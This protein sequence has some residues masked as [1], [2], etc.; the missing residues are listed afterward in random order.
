MK[1]NI[2]CLLLTLVAAGAHALPKQFTAEYTLSTMGLEIGDT[3]RTLRAEGDDRF[4]FE[5]LSVPKGIATWFIS[6]TLLERSVWQ[7]VN[8]GVQPQ[9]YLYRRSGGRKNKLI[10]MSFDWKD[11]VVQGLDG[12]R[13]WHMD[14]P[15][16]TLD[17]L[18]FQLALM[19]DL[20]QGK[21][22]LSYPIADK[23]EVSVYNVRI[24]GNEDV[25]TPLGTF[26]TIKVQQV[27]KSNERG[28]TLWAAPSLDFM[29]VKIEYKE[30]GGQIYRSLLRS[31][32][33]IAKP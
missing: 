3:R 17:K 13:H 26:K 14:L 8:G 30:K 28:L 16:G 1:A 10:E 22:K 33:G 11:R 9:E 7:D 23:G 27:R 20:K 31:L 5:S 21:R 15:E 25:K 19:Q 6:D 32:Q 29:P 12:S 4:V 24:L 18:S 2:A